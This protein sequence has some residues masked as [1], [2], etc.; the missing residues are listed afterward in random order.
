MCVSLSLPGVPCPLCL[1]V[2]SSSPFPPTLGLS[3]LSLSPL[4]LSRVRALSIPPPPPPRHTSSFLR[5]LVPSF[6]HIHR[7][8]CLL[9][10]GLAFRSGLERPP[11]E[12]DEP[13]VQ[14]FKITLEKERM[15]GQWLFH[16]C[17]SAQHAFLFNGDS[18]G[19]TTD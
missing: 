3:P 10:Y 13:E 8:P 18:G 11:A 17:V 12:Q 19:T 14:H 9:I 16:E 6:S 15:T 7:P 5:S 1:C 4:S 2:V